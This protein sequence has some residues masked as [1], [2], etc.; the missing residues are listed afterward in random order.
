MRILKPIALLVLII[1]LNSCQGFI[2]KQ[3]ANAEGFKT[4]EKTIKDKFGNNAYYTNLTI[5]HD[6]TIGNSIRVTVTQDPESLKMSEWNLTQNNWKQSSNITVEI[7]LGTKPT[8][9]M[10]QLDDKINL[11]KLEELVEKSKVKLTKEKKIENP[12]LSMTHVKFPENGG[13]NRTEY[14]VQLK[15]ENGGTTFS[16]YYNLSGELKEMNY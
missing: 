15:P 8:D 1:A 6:K 11:A 16:F 12:T 4:I 2:A 14:I 7:P 13:G 10:F 9:F 3:S 5:I